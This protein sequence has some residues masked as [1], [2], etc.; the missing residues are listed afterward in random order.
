MRANWAWPTSIAVARAPRSICSRKDGSI[1]FRVLSG[2]VDIANGGLKIP[3]QG[4]PLAGVLPGH[5]DLLDFAAKLGEAS[6]SG[7]GQSPD[8]GVHGCIAEI[9]TPRRFQTAQV[10]SIANGEPVVD[11]ALDGHRVAR[12]G[13]SDAIQQQ[14][15]I[16]DRAG[17]RSVVRTRSPEVRVRPVGDH[18]EGG[19]EAEDAAQRGGDADGAGAVG[20]M[21]YGPN[22]SRD[23]CG[24]AAARAT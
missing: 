7:R 6:R 19:F 16:A 8:L 1:Q 20:A 11:R 23:G 5:A 17:D 18:A 15:G 12:I 21:G 13:A 3:E 4:G 24:R 14:R 2:T 9:R 10:R 22:A